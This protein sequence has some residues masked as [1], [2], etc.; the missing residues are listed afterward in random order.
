MWPGWEDGTST[1]RRARSQPPTHHVLPPTL[2]GPRT[3]GMVV[4]T[5]LALIPILFLSYCAV[6][7][8]SDSG[9]QRDYY[10]QS[11]CQSTARCSVRPEPSINPSLPGPSFVPTPSP[12][13]S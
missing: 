9:N 12:A 2:D 1:A 4:L 5:V 7:L 13:P 11:E 3:T 8:R 6:V 10:R